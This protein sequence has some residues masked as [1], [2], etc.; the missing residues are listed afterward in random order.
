MTAFAGLRVVEVCAGGH[1]SAAIVTTIDEDNAGVK[2]I[3]DDEKDAKNAEIDTNR[4][5]KS[6][7]DVLI[8][9]WNVNDTVTVR[10]N[11]LL[12]IF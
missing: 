4:S 8:C 10:K 1:A 12:Y 3:D 11:E 9:S 7:I 5:N 6:D 2:Q